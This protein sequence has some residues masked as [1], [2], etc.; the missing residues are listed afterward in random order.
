M[1]GIS[2][3]RHKIVV[4]FNRRIAAE[5]RIRLF[6]CG[7]GQGDKRCW[8]SRERSDNF[9][10]PVINPFFALFAELLLNPAAIFDTVTIE[11]RNI[12]ASVVDV[13]ARN[14]AIF[15]RCQ[16]FNSLFAINAGVGQ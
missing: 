1:P 8:I 7:N 16:H 6:V 3:R 2:H 9:F 5:S 10:R 15:E 14:Q 12:W 4:G 13:G 11:V